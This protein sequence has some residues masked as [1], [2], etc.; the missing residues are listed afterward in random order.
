MHRGFL[1]ILA[2][3]FLL[4]QPVFAQEPADPADATE[5]AS[6]IELYTTNFNARDATAL[7]ELWSDRG[8]YNDRS[9]GEQIVGKAAIAEEFERVFAQEDLPQLSVET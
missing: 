9:T 1:A 2:I 3:F 5:L 8:V 6:V 4:G 7:A